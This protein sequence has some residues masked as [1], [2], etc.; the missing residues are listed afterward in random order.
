MKKINLDEGSLSLSGYIGG[1]LRAIRYEYGWSGDELAKD[2]NISQQQ[3]SRYERGET[4]FQLDMLF[5]FFSALRM[6]ESE[7]Q[8]FFYLIINK[9]GE[10]PKYKI[11]DTA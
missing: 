10:I 8:Y 9:A 4:G 7:I 1:Q 6:N 2:M 3:V 5:R 11:R